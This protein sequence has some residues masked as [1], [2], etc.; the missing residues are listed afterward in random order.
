MATPPWEAV[1]AA[2]VA[3]LAAGVSTLAALRSLQRAGAAG[4]GDELRRCEVAVGSGLALAG[5]VL[6]ATHAL[7]AP[8]FLKIF[9][10]DLAYSWEQKRA[11]VLDTDR[12]E[13]RCWSTDID[14]NG[15]MNN[16]KFLRVLNYARRSF[17]T[18]NGGWHFVGSRAPPTNMVVTA[19]TIRYRR[20]IKCW[21]VYAV[22][23]RLLHWDGPNFYLEHRFESLKDGFVLAIC[24]V[25]YRL[26]SDDKASAAEVLGCLDS[27][28]RDW[29]PSPAPELAAWI[30]FDEL[31][32]KALRP[33]GRS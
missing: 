29:S 22:A 9:W 17:W 7:D 10:Q 6:A 30:S 2:G 28:V 20:E 11:S 18:R 31:S 24:F 4:G 15:H 1:L 16:A 13:Y 26:V 23:T 27:A 5:A 8:H 14:R 21:T 19:S 25:K 32:S 12:V 33:Q 3:G